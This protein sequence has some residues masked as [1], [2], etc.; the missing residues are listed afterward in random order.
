MCRMYLLICMY[1]I[2]WEN[3]CGCSGDGK[4]KS[5]KGKEWEKVERKKEEMGMERDGNKEGERKKELER[6]KEKRRE[7]VKE[8]ETERERR[9]DKREERVRPWREK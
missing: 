4:G 1:I 3:C 2:V 6:E 8:G 7:M 5:E 9:T